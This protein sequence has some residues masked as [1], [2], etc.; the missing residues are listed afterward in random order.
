M[1][2]NVAR[3]LNKPKRGKAHKRQNRSHYETGSRQERQKTKII[4]GF[5]STSVESQRKVLEEDR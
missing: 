1:R 5:N 2:K 4:P 3:L